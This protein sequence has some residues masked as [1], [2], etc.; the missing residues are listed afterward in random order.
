MS[1]RAAYATAKT[2]DVERLRA[3]FESGSEWT[4]DLAHH[5]FGWNERRFRAAVEAL[6]DEGMPIVSWSEK[7]STYR[8]AR[9]AAEADRF[10]DTELVPRIRKLERRARRIRESKSRYFTTHQQQLI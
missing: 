7:D 5:H 3:S 2:E 10:V 9:D 4:K 1:E 6:R 8:M